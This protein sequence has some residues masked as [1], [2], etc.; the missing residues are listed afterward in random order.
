MELVYM[1]CWRSTE[2]VHV[3]DDITKQSRD[4]DAG[5]QTSNF[6]CSCVPKQI[7]TEN[8]L[9][10][11][12]KHERAQLRAQIVQSPEKLQVPVPIKQCWI[13]RWLTTS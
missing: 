4:P 11:Q 12:A 5:I 2:R 8:F 9:G 3:T 6:L 10:T 7:A 1:Q 13:W